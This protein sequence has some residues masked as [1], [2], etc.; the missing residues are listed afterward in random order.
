[1]FKSLDLSPSEF[2]VKLKYL[3]AA[4]DDFTWLTSAT[5]KT[6]P[7]PYNENLK[8]KISSEFNSLIGLGC[9][10]RFELGKE[11]EVRS[12]FDQ[13]EIQKDYLL[14]YLS[15]EL[16]NKFEFI[17]SSN[18]DRM[19]MGLAVFVKP[20]VVIKITNEI[21][22][23]Q[24]ENKESE[25]RF[26]AILDSIHTIDEINSSSLTESKNIVIPSVNLTEK[27]YIEKVNQIK[28]HIYRGDIYEINFCIEF[29]I[30]NY[31]AKI[32]DLFLDLMNLSPNPFSGFIK[33][34]G[35]CAANYILCASPERFLKKTDRKLI[36]Q[37]IKGTAARSIEV[38]ADEILK[39]ELIGN[40]K[41]VSENVMIVD[42]VR[43]DLSRVAQKGSVKVEELLGLYSFPQ[44]HQMISTISCEIKE[45]ISLFE[46]LKANFPMG[47]MTG[48]PKIKAMELIDEF[49][50]FNRGVFSGSIGYFAPN[51]DFDFNV[52]IRSILY[53][54]E[55]KRLSFPVG[56]AIT[57]NAEP[58]KEYEECK[59]KV[60][61]ILTV[62]NNKYKS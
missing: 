33:T 20:E 42:L 36:A 46:I 18:L 35:S 7:I 53:N 41:E 30:E 12:F 45:N 24:A 34:K 14:G 4:Y 9:V 11:D 49:E 15:Y 32:F 8:L 26:L 52:I 17:T 29:F 1:M 43:N 37:P 51:G 60:K 40:P 48:A 21:V 16:K 44:V 56:S 54:S 27:E 38:K 61:A 39:Q 50:T 10:Q 23:Y 59:L 58:A 3:E 55:I 13:I 47:S 57:K 22:T 31:T 62:L 19:N 25:S 6:A 28:S 5:V 2:T